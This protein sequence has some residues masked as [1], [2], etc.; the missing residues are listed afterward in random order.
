MPDGY[1]VALGVEQVHGGV[2]GAGGTARGGHVVP[3]VPAAG[4]RGG[5]VVRRVRVTAGQ[6][7]GVVAELA[8]PV[9]R[10]GVVAVLPGAVRGV[11]GRQRHHA[12]DAGGAG[13]VGRDGGGYLAAGGGAQQYQPVGVEVEVGG[14]VADPVQRGQGVGSL[15]RPGSVE[16]QPVVDVEDGVT[17]VGEGARPGG[18]AGV[19][20]PVAAVQDHDP[21]LFPVPLFTGGVPVGVEGL[22]GVRTVGVRGLVA[23]GRRDVARVRKDEGCDGGNA[24]N[25]TTPEPTHGYLLSSDMTAG[26]VVPGHEIRPERPQ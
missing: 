26:D 1:E 7:G 10:T 13:A 22:P 21:R 23:V 19:L 2:V 6:D 12:V 8:L 24:K 5:V 3:G 20:V 14:V 16:I 17:G 18:P 4:V 25:Q 15:G 9:A 11:H